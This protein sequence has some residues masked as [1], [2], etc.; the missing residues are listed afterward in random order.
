M[1]PKIK[2][3][4]TGF[5]LSEEGKMPKQSLFTMGSFLS[6]AVIGGIL[7]TKNNVAEH[8]NSVLFDYNA[9]DPEPFVVEHAHHGSHSSH[10]NHSSY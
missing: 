4:I 8:T 5:L 3:K 1:I 2:K 6:A 7:A 10:G 9:G